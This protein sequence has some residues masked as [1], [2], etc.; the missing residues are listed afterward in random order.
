MKKLEPI[1]WEAFR[2]SSFPCMACGE[3]EAKFIR[4]HENWQLPLCDRCARLEWEEIEKALMPGR[5]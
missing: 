5:E 3:R 1:T 4:H 2:P